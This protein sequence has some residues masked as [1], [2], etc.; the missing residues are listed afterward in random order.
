M[1]PRFQEAQVPSDIV[2]G[3]PSRRARQVQCLVLDRV[4]ILNSG[5]PVAMSQLRCAQ[6]WRLN[7]RE[8]SLIRL[9]C[10]QWLLVFLIAVIDPWKIYLCRWLGLCLLFLRESRDRA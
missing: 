2:I 7:S 3:V 5:D 10:I 9:K 6:S 8:R 4:A 1:A